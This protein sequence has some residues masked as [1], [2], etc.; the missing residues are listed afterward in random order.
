MKYSETYINLWDVLDCWPESEVTFD[1]S[2]RGFFLKTVT[3]S[4]PKHYNN[5]FFSE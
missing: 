1:N 2:G 5:T 3:F 4:Q